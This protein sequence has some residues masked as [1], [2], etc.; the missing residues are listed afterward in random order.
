MI[1]RLIVKGFRKLRDFEWC[2]KEGM[3]IIVGANAAG[4]STVLEAIELVM[5]GRLRG[6]SVR[7]EISPYWFNA[8]IVSGFFDSLNQSDQSSIGLPEIMIEAYFDETAPGDIRGMHNSRSEDAPGLQVLIRVDEGLCTEFIATCMDDEHDVKTLPTDYFKFEWKTF[9]GEAI[10]KTPKGVSCSRID[11]LP[12]NSTRA[13]D[14]YARNAVDESLDASQVRNVS[15]KYRG[16]RQDV[17]QAI[18]QEMGGSASSPNQLHE[19]GFRMDQSPRSDWRN[20][21]IMDFDGV[22]LPYAGKGNEVMTRAHIAMQRTSDRRVLLVEEPECH[23][24][25]TS[26]FRLIELFKESLKNRQMFVSTH[27]P[28]VLN[29]LGIDKLSLISDGGSPASIGQLTT[30]TVSY[31]QRLSGYDTLR[32][33]LAKRIVL[34]EGPSDEMVFRWAY[35]KQTGHYPEKDEVDVMEYGTRGKRALELCSAMDRALVAVLRDND[36]VQPS[37]WL[38]DASDYTCDGK[39]QMFVGDPND[40][41]TLE[42]QFVKAN[43]ENLELVANTVGASCS[44]ENGLTEY[45]KS[46]KT[47]WALKL[48]ES[49]S[50]AADLNCPQYIEEAITFINGGA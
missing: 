13:I 34:V 17:D 9:K 32:I 49:G 1:K 36:G 12:R 22:P 44:D 24:S 50:I 23:L 31:F 25:H 37:K 18:L 47:D 30:G 38:G 41:V 14:A 43:L 48:L 20:S 42:P 35:E 16:L 26:L 29:R 10:L 33:V 28:F 8:E 27:S 5:S 21:V 19:M 15:N 40:G 39:R 3:N 11:S 7:S 46:H 2:P 4:K 45:M 6:R